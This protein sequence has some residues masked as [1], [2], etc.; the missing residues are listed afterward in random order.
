M[1]LNK[2][3]LRRK[4]KKRL[5]KRNLACLRNYSVQTKIRKTSLNLIKLINLEKL[6][7]LDTILTLS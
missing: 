4:R 7:I 2:F 6:M 1:N 5:S 3:K